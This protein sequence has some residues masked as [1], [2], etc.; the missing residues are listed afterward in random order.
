MSASP[1]VSL[2]NSATKP[3]SLWTSKSN[4][5][6][7]LS[8]MTSS[9]RQRY[10]KFRQSPSRILALRLRSKTHGQNK[11]YRGAFELAARLRTDRLPLVMLQTW[12]AR[13][14]IQNEP[15][16]NTSIHSI[17]PSDWADRFNR[18]ETRGWSKEDV[19]HW[20]WIMSGEDGDVRVQRLVSTETLTPI[21]L[22]SILSRSDERIFKAETLLSLMEYASKHHF[23]SRPQLSGDSLAVPDLKMTMTVAQYLLFLR[24]LVNHVQRLWPRSI[25][26]LARL[27]AQYIQGMP[28]SVDAHN[29]HD[30]CEIFNK[31][32]QLFKKPAVFQ[33]IVN[34]EFNWR[35]Q[36]ILL[37]MSDNLEKPLI[38]NKYSYRAVR[39]VMVG[40]KKSK[41][42]RAVAIRYTKSWP[43]YRQ[44]FDG[45][46]AKRTPDDNYSRSVKAGVLMK[47]AGYP[48]DHYDQA[49]SALGGVGTDSPTIQTRSI[50]PKE[51][52]GEE[53]GQNVFTEWAMSIRATRNSQEA[54]KVFNKFDPQTSKSP[55][56]QVYAEM[57]IKLH[58]PPIHQNS[59]ALPGDSRE[60][61][62]IHDA[63]YTEYELAR[64]SPPTVGELYDR[65]VS[66]GVKP[67]GQC[68]YTLLTN[69][70]SLEEAS[71]YLHDNGLDSLSISALLP[72]KEA[73][74]EVLSRVPLLVFK[75]Y[76]QLLC[77]L[78]PQRPDKEKIPLQDLF[79]IRHAIKLCSLRL[80]PRT[81]EG[82]TFGLPWSIILRA[83]A[84]PHIC[85]VNG[86]RTDN[87]AQ[88]LSISMDV[89]QHVQNRTGINPE[90]FLYICRAAQKAAAS[91]LGSLRTPLESG[92]N[93]ETSLV[94]SAEPILRTLKTIF[95][96]L[97]KPVDIVRSKSGGLE[98]PRFMHN[99]EPVHLHTYMRTL[100]FLED[101][102]A[103]KELLQWM[104]TNKAYIDEEAER[105]GNRGQ[106]LIVKTLCA[107]QAFARLRLSHDEE[108]DIIS[109]IENTAKIAGSWRWPTPEDVQNYIQSDLRGGSQQLQQR[110]A[111]KAFL[112]SQQENATANIQQKKDFE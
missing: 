100:A 105:I 67:E 101:T 41:T 9:G 25:V 2:A 29:Y 79:H 55:T 98:A 73:S 44:D 28:S 65:M 5:S 82:S 35:A 26:T 45:L 33:P 18:L 38:I 66:H 86:T 27:T 59:T 109:Q 93:G 71:R 110:I 111:G 87:D 49:L 4:W 61:L 16:V 70:D 52:K 88:T 94:P 95:S 50:P 1:A 43:P 14:D 31:A 11:A 80:R 39:E 24:R 85:V 57:F 91:R 106:A 99:I 112:A 84:R 64:L 97:T 46:D 53:Q 34:M 17:T 15:H 58:A 56:V 63:N 37:A 74:Y 12:M 72:F 96:Q 47:E 40:L 48:D 42:E 22:M 51:W 6:Q 81:T 68:L 103:M 60:A 104:L 30:K 83:L 54:W 75:S 20:I 78:Q 8:R 90:M 23:H 92:R 69:A 77:R 102:E 108:E 62:P 32:L 10:P 13:Q 21:F 7:T 89:I 3:G 76:I 19:D 107:F 36:K